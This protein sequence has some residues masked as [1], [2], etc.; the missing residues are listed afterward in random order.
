MSGNIL[1]YKGYHTKVLYDADSQ[2]LHGKIEGIRDFV[3]FEADSISDVEREFH[4]A[5]D[6]YLDFCDEVGK[7][8]DKEYK[9]TFNVRIAP[10]LHRE[11]AI[12]ASKQDT[13]LNQLVESAIDRYLHGSDA[14]PTT[15]IINAADHKPFSEAQPIPTV[16][17]PWSMPNFIAQA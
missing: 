9:G 17:M 2:C 6:E 1:E 12:E 11:L 15:I 10:S 14:S 3:N 7:E 5:V 13:T 4:A 16:T 8:P